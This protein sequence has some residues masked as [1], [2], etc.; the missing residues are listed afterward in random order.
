MKNMNKS[1]NEIL[2]RV[3]EH[4]TFEKEEISLI[5]KLASNNDYALS[6]IG[7]IIFAYGRKE[8]VID[9]L[10]ELSKRGISGDKLVSLYGEYNK[11]PVEFIERVIDGKLDY[12]LRRDYD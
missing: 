11:D 9:V 2:E 6:V 3:T 10:E 12:L 4:M 8:F 1:E 5:K 7:D